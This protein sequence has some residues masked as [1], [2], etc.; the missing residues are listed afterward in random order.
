MVIQKL[1]DRFFQDKV[2]DK[3]YLFGGLLETPEDSRDFNV[4]IF[5][6]GEYKPLHESRIIPTKSIKNQAPHNT[7]GW[8]TVTVQKES[9]EGC[10]LSVR[11]LVQ[12]AKKLGRVTSNGFSNLRD[13]QK[14]VQEYGIP[15]T[16]RFWWEDA[17]DWNEYSRYLWN[18]EAEANA[19][20]HRSNSYWTVNVLG[21]MLKALDDGR[22]LASGCPWFSG[23]NMSGG[24]RHPWIIEKPSGYS[25]GGHAVPIIGYDL[26][27]H[28]Y[29]VFVC[30]QHAGQEWG[31]GGK[32][33]VPFEYV[34]S[35]FYARYVQMDI[36]VDV[37]KFIQENNGKFVKAKGQPAIYLIKEGQKLPF[38]NMLAYF[39]WGGMRKGYSIVEMDSL[40]KIPDGGI[41][42]VGESPYYEY[43]KNINLQGE[44]VMGEIMEEVKKA[45]EDENTFI[46]S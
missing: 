42:T 45:M 22:I 12:K 7:C 44:N 31:D 21:D 35:N 5:G 30:Q 27:Y 43:L 26:N 41:L 8:N 18:A 46:N 11:G 23:F 14:T 25:V 13:N 9:D 38:E 1:K 33:Y 24:F 17:G 32:F 29:K 15:E 28:G 4:G 34:L 16:N 6:W 40:S 3:K 37:A 20:T 19:F 10:V 39:A 2:G 36:T